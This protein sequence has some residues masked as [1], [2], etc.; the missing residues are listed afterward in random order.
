MDGNHT[1]VTAFFPS[2]DQAEKAYLE[3]PDFGIPIE[4]V[5]LIG[6]H[7]DMHLQ[8]EEEHPE[9]LG[10]YRGSHLTV[11][12]H[13]I[14][15]K[16]S[17]VAD[18]AFS[19]GMIGAVFGI[20]AGMVLA[21]AMLLLPAA[22]LAIAGPLV[23][24]LIG[25]SVKAAESI[26]HALCKMGMDQGEAKQITAQIQDRVKHGGIVMAVAALKD[27]AAQVRS[28]LEKVGGQPLGMA[29]AGVPRV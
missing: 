28:V 5:S 9:V 21:S 29:G 16:D 14:I 1:L 13:R 11:H 27:Q 25:G 3:M 7:G 10:K 18:G 20:G 4:D 23:G 17:S 15:V 6:K 12:D 22:G 26:P 2:I 24:A 8:V 19:G